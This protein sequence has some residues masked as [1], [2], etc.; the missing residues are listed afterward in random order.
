M[1]FSSLS[2]P[3]SGLVI[4]ILNLLNRPLAA[5]RP[6]HQLLQ[7]TF[8][9]TNATVPFLCLTQELPVTYAAGKSTP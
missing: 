5:T 7:W 1:N 9:N 4:S 3:I 6:P 2:I 8:P